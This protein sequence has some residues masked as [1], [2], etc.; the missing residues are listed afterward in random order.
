MSAIVTTVL[1]GLCGVLTAA[2]LS[3]RSKTRKGTLL[4]S[5][6]GILCSLATGA[7]IF[8]MKSSVREIA[9]QRMPGM[10]GI[11]RLLPEIA[12]PDTLM[13]YFGALAFISAVTVF[14]LAFNCRRNSGKWYWAVLWSVGLTFFFGHIVFMPYFYGLATWLTLWGVQKGVAFFQPVNATLPTGCAMP[15]ISLVSVALWTWHTVKKAK[16]SWKNILTFAGVCTGAI[17]ILWLSAWGVGTWAEKAVDRKA[18]ELG[19]TPLQVADEEPAELKNPEFHNFYTR[20]SK[21]NPPRSGR[22]NWRKN[23]IPAE[24]KEY[25]LKFFDSP[26]LEAHLELLKKSSKY[27]KRK[28]V[29]YLSAFQN[30]RSLV[31]H[32]ADKAELYYRSGKVDKVVPELLKYLEVDALIP[33]DTPFL[34]SE[35][36]RTATRGLWVEAVV[37]YA[38]DDKKYSATYREL[39]KW[40]KSWQIHV[41][42][43][44]G[45]YLNMRMVSSVK[46]AVKIFYAPLE[47]AVRYRGF[48]DAVK[49]I[50]ELEKLQRMEVLS[51]Y[52]LF[53]KNAATQQ[54][55]IAMGR[56]ALALKLYRAE[57]GRYPEK[58]SAL[59]PAY[60]PKVY[61][62][63]WSGKEFTYTVKD[64]NF[65]LISGKRSIS[66]GR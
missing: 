65:T 66:S 31:R 41:P 36:V 7:A 30:F 33:A 49:R 62:S 29:L 54:Q 15:L 19:I 1:L 3:G 26:E 46:G 43:E 25:T 60:L 12:I 50:P 64:G 20:H 42:H 23:E 52:D 2:L 57:H 63:A 13:F 10:G 53:S 8:C 5:I 22:Y 59:V 44:A 18:A 17:G 51:Q 27:L 6:G 37:Q 4:W 38:P 56:T 14:L 48:S 55:M 28:D 21:Y 61:R 58:L 35:L 9:L 16:S 32:R 39:L 24:E 40:S 45:M 34:L 11:H 47:N